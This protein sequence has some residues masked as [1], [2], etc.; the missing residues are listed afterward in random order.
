MNDVGY[1]DIAYKGSCV[2]NKVKSIQTKE[3]LLYRRG[4]T[5]GAIEF[6][7][8]EQ[9]PKQILFFESELKLIDKILKQKRF[10]TQSI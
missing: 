7:K 1:I 6:H 2:E 9:N 5:L 4:Y 3:N 8:R 10:N